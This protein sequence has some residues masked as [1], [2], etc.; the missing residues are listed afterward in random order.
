MKELKQ[1]AINKQVEL[2]SLKPYD[3]NPYIHEDE[4]IKELEGSIE[5][6]GYISQIV[7]WK[8]EVLAGHKRYIAMMKTYPKKTLINVI[9][10][11]YLNIKQAQKYRIMENESR[12][13]SVD[14]M[15]MD[16][17]LQDIY[18]Y[19]NEQHENIKLETGID[20]QALQEEHRK[21][22]SGMKDMNVDPEEVKSHSQDVKKFGLDYPIKKAEE[23]KGLCLFFEQN[24]P[25]SGIKGMSDIFLHLLKEYRK[26]YG[27]G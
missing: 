21:I 14:V 23:V 13:G 24:N 15:K 27:L 3:K 2:G 16:A 1:K 25:E 5:N 20:Y 18:Q 17:E 11:S 4:E 26:N 9:D 12:R 22:L 7:I 6:F 8:G 19:A 10:A